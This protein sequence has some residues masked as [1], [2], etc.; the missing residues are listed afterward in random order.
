MPEETPP[1]KYQFC[2]PKQATTH[3]S[4]PVVLGKLRLDFRAQLRLIL[5][6]LS[7]GHVFESLQTHIKDGR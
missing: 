2:A 6:N 7:D 5:E 4:V 1:N 3:L